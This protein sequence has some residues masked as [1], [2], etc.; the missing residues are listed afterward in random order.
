MLYAR[1]PTER[2]GVLI[3]PGGETKTRLHEA[4]GVIVII[5]SLTGEVT[6]D[7]SRAKDPAMALNVRDIVR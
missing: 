7:E 6:I 4:S 2:I 3:G 1:I 5:D